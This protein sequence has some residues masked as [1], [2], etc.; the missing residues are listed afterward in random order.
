MALLGVTLVGPS[1][2]R[3]LPL[4]GGHLPIWRL[5]LP[6]PYW[7]GLLHLTFRRTLSRGSRGPTVWSSEIR[8]Q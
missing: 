4:P 7:L 3:T 8:E 2:M 6:W 1:P 5:Q